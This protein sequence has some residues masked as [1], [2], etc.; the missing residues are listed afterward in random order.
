MGEGEMRHRMA[1]ING[2]RGK[3]AGL[4]SSRKAIFFTLGF[5]LVSLAV[6][7]FTKFVFNESEDEKV[8]FQDYA[9]MNRL[10]DLD[11]SLQASMKDTFE[12]YSNIKARIGNST[13]SFE[14]PL[15]NSMD[16]FEHKLDRLKRFAE[17]NETAIYININDTL[18][19]SQI[20]VSPENL[21]YRHNFSAK[22]IIIDFPAD[23]SSILKHKMT[24][25]ADANITCDW[26]FYPGSF[27]YELEVISV[28]DSGCDHERMVDLGRNATIIILSEDDAR[29]RITIYLS[30]LSFRIAMDSSSVSSVIAKNEIYLKDRPGSMSFG[31]SLIRINF[32]DFGLKREGGFRIS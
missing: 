6:L 14:E 7:S 4:R 18:S 17:N 15:P 23:S 11:R 31:N 21:T 8:L 30:P 32:T 29:D 2:K 13:I 28:D 27:D 20:T 25:A 9:V 19:S 24:F 12:R 26:S 1:S 3:K 16:A 22:E 5:V 10:D